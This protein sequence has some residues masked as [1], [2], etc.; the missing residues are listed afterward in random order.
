[1]QQF[2]LHVDPPRTRWTFVAKGHI[3]AVLH[4]QTKFGCLLQQQRVRICTPYL[5]AEVD[6]RALVRQESQGG[7]ERS[8]QSRSEDDVSTANGVERKKGVTLVSSFA[9][10]EHTCG[11]RDRRTEPRRCA[12]Q[13]VR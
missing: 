9:N 5:E 1:M 10:F 13:P 7:E 12:P 6:V 4:S 11:T 3:G 2:A 8:Y